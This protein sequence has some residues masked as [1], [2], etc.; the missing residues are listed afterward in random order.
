MD[1]DQVKGV[2]ETVSCDSVKKLDDKD[3]TMGFKNINI[4]SSPLVDKGGAALCPITP[5]SNKEGVNSTSK[6]ISP[7]I[8]S[9]SMSID[10]DI[11]STPMEDVFDSLAGG[12]D[13]LMKHGEKSE[14]YVARKLNFNSGDKERASDSRFGDGTV[15]ES[16]YESILDG[17]ISKEAEDILSEIVAADVLMTPPAAPRLSGVAETCPGAPMRPAT[18]LRNVDTRLC[19]R[20]LEF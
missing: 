18:K 8:A 1:V 10:D 14:S 16:V 5:F 9:S 6:V 4:S 7:S 11:P 20:K 3:A 19:R 17:I 12:R 15:M 2:T 13:K